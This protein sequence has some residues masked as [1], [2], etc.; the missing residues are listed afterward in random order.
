METKICCP[1]CGSKALNL[2]GSVTRTLMFCPSWTDEQ[3]RAHHHDGNRTTSSYSCRKCGAEFAEISYG[4]CWCGWSGG[5]TMIRWSGGESTLSELFSI[6]RYDILGKKL[7]SF[8]KGA[9][10]ATIVF[11]DGGSIKMT[12]SVDD[13]GKPIM[14][15]SMTVVRVIE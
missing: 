5:E 15:Y 6:V 14:E 1:E 13:S 2:P 11:D 8:T 3:G 12:A 9:R 7:A 10:E 4:R